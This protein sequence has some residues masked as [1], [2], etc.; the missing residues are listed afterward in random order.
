MTES[1]YAATHAYI[2]ENP[3]RRISVSGVLNH[4]GVSKSGYYSWMN[5]APSR[6]I[7]LKQTVKTAIRK[8]YDESKQIYG[9]P[10]I[11]K[12]LH[13]QGFQTTERTV[14]RYMLEMG[15]RAC[16]T[17]PYTVTTHSEDF[18]DSL[19]N[20]LQRD[21]HPEKPNAVWCTDI[22]YIPTQKGFVYLSCIMDLFSRKIVAWELAPTLE[23]NYVI[24]AVRKAIH[25]TG[26]RPAVIHTDR[27]T[28]YTSEAYRKQTEG[29][30]KSYSSKG[31]PWDNAC[32]ES[33]HAL[34]KREWLNRFVIRDIEHAHALVFEY[35]DSF[36]NTRRVHSFCG[37]ESPL[38]FE[39][40]YYRNRAEG[41]KHTA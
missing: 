9:A 32:I 23:T 40:Q 20:I 17:K 3:K 6:Q 5:R 14:T 12:E 25:T 26:K 30:E 36:Y 37:Y 10:K 2:S 16:W 22:T 4:L 15:I 7:R 1:I 11:A 33:F 31:S 35:I 19:K 41:K 24:K 21:F 34:I 38:H 8:I 27:G 18:S 39:A 28:Q 29:I 13:K